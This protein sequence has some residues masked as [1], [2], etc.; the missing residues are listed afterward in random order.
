MVG[1]RN[2]VCRLVGLPNYSAYPSDF[3]MQTAVA[4]GFLPAPQS[5]APPSPAE[6][7]GDLEDPEIA[8]ILEG[9]RTGSQK[10]PS[11][12]LQTTR[13][14][15]R[16][17]RRIKA[18]FRTH[19]NGGRVKLTQ[20]QYSKHSAEVIEKFHSMILS[21]GTIPETM[22]TKKFAQRVLGREWPASGPN[23]TATSLPDDYVHYSQPRILTAREWARLQTFPDWY[24][25]KGPRTTGGQ[26]RAGN[27]RDGK[28]E[29]EVPIY[30]QIGN[31][32]P[33]K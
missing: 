4:T 10:Y 12:K 33:V 21:Q 15:A 23:V 19:P 5:N 18:E 14:P 11:G 2:D 25:F 27:P 28:F 29:R 26:R 13:Y 1:I 16:A 3:T 20:H 32:V 8:N 22:R 30:T 6:L 7:L 24:E 9:V 31:A 17:T